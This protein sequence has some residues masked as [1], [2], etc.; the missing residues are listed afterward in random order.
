MEVIQQRNTGDSHYSYFHDTHSGI[1]AIL[2]KSSTFTSSKSLH[3]N[4]PSYP[5]I[6]Y[7][8]SH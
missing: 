8:Q 1:T 4:D 3:M 6:S 5:H 2:S 7:S